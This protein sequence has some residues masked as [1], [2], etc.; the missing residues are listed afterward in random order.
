MVK[1]LKWA[2]IQISL[3]IFWSFNSF[4]WL[5]SFWNPNRFPI[6]K[7]RE[8]NVSHEENDEKEYNYIRSLNQNVSEKWY[9]SLLE[10]LPINFINY[11]HLINLK[12]LLNSMDNLCEVNKAFTKSS[13]K[14][15]NG[16]RKALVI[17]LLTAKK[18]NLH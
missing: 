2:P 16:W 12:Q 5:N 17:F 8:L 9:L 1:T 18:W 3:S 13:K 7:A 10:M 6:N 4:F 15:Q 14:K 11:P